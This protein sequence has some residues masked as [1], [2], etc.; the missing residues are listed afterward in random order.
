MISLFLRMKS[1][2][3]IFFFAGLVFAQKV[4]I[5]QGR[6][7]NKVLAQIMKQVRLFL[8]FKNFVKLI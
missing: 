4:E 8:I 3:L 6:C 7:N 5:E 1:A 2:V